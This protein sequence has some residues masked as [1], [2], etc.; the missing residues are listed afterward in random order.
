M[1]NLGTSCNALT[2]LCSVLDHRQQITGFCVHTC[3]VCSYSQ[4][5]DYSFRYTTAPATKS[6]QTKKA[7]WSFHPVS[8]HSSDS[9]GIS[10]KI[11]LVKI[12]RTFVTKN[13]GKKAKGATL[14]YNYPCKTLAYLMLALNKQKWIFLSPHL[15]GLFLQTTEPTQLHSFREEELLFISRQ[16][17]VTIK[18]HFKIILFPDDIGEAIYLLLDPSPNVR[19]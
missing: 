7:T 15:H 3:S 11:Q 9:K 16:L 13:S 2:A 1:T 17:P 12:L 5:Q 14:K 10:A 4:N 8:F 19:E 6:C 18:L